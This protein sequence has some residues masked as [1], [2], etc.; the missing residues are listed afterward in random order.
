MN[1]IILFAIALLQAPVNNVPEG[2]YQLDLLSYEGPTGYFHDKVSGALVQYSFGFMPPLPMDVAGSSKCKTRAIRGIVP[3]CLINIQSI[4]K[5][6]QKKLNVSIGPIDHMYAFYW[7]EVNSSEQEERARSLMLQSPLWE[8]PIAG[9]KALEREPQDPDVSTLK[10]G[11]NIKEVYAILGYPLNL[12]P[13]LDSGFSAY[14]AIWSKH[15]PV[16]NW[17][18]YQIEL[19]FTKD[20]ILKSIL[21]PNKPKQK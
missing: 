8:R 1:F 18:S 2:W 17:G 7:T 12:Q 19:V 16:K 4:P 13:K 3:N 21:L 20:R 5:T 14:Y 6:S 9:Q 15:G 11:M 10:V